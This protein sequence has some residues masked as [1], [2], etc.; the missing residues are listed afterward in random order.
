MG[1]LPGARLVPSR[2]GWGWHGR[3]G[4]FSGELALRSRC[5]VGHSAVRMERSAA[6][7]KPQRVAQARALWKAPRRTVDATCRGVGHFAVQVLQI[8]LEQRQ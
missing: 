5:G 3:A 6:C 4:K 2:S 8:L 7:P 1:I